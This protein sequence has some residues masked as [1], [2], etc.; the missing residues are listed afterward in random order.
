ML[1]E[2]I[3]TALV[4]AALAL[5]AL[6]GLPVAGFGAALL[7]VIL[8]AAW[9]WARLAGFSAAPA[10]WGYVGAVLLLILASWPWVANKSFVGGL[11]AVA[12]AGWIGAL[13]WLK[14]FA[15]EPDPT[16]PR[17]SR[18]PAGWC[19]WRLGSR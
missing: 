4:L 14:R 10:R 18:R 16:A 15:D 17:R 1:R 7:L 6:F 9:E 3:L 11:L 5:G 19:W 13:V 8:P 12:A 2:R